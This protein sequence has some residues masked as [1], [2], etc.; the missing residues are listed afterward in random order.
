[1]NP[2]VVDF[3]YDG[4]PYKALITPNG[5]NDDKSYGVK[6]ESENQELYLDIV[7]NPCGS[8]KMD[9]CLKET[10]EGPNSGFDKNLLMEIGEA[11]EKY[12][13]SNS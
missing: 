5:E 4:F 6:L 9:W 10:A 11:I 8:D 1:M 3:L 2:F 12:E 7:A 13:I